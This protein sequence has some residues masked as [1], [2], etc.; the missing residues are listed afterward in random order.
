[1]HIKSPII[2]K[3]NDCLFNLLFIFIVFGIVELFC[4]GILMRGWLTA[5][6]ADIAAEPD[7]WFFLIFLW[8]NPIEAIL[9]FSLGLFLRTSI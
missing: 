5:D 3:S 4:T 2:G 1:M 9:S 8:K 6:M 7:N